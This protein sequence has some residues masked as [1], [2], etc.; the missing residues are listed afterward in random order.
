MWFD[1]QSVLE[2]RKESHFKKMTV[3]ITLLGHAKKVKNLFTISNFH[4]SDKV[5][6]QNP[7]LILT[8]NIIYKR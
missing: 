2:Q 7:S 6:P 8:L 5:A 1:D 3:D 4:N